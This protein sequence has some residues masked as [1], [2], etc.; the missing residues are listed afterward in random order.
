MI[1]SR[2]NYPHLHAAFVQ[3]EQDHGGH[4][5]GTVYPGKK[6]NLEEFKI[7]EA[8]A[9][10]VSGAEAGLKRL[11]ET[12]YGDHETFVNGEQSEAEEIEKRQGD[13]AEARIILNDWF[14]G[15]QPEDAPFASTHS[16]QHNSRGTQGE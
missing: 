1:V 12:S 6:I 3:I 11:Q 15:W 8:W 9:H 16:S 7:P 5:I 10:L 2:H 14:N 4:L 13:L